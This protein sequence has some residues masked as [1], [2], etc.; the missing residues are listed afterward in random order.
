[1]SRTLSASQLPTSDFD[2][3]SGHKVSFSTVGVAPIARYYVSGKSGSF[4]PVLSSGVLLWK[5]IG[6]SVDYHSDFTTGELTDACSAFDPD[7]SGSAPLKG[8]RQSNGETLLLGLG[9]NNGR[10]G[11]EARAER[12]LGGG[13]RAASGRF[14]FGSTLSLVMR[15]HPGR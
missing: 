4:R 3:T 5:S 13:A 11:M 15:V 14:S 10:I 9:L 8:L 1:M 12:V 7:G 2:F 6:C